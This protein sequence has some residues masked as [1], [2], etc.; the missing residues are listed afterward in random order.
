MAQHLVAEARVGDKDAWHEVAG[1]VG[2]GADGIKYG[3]VGDSGKHHL[4]LGDVALGEEERVGAA[5][6]RALQLGTGAGGHDHGQAQTLGLVE[7]GTG[8]VAVIRA[9]DGVAGVGLHVGRFALAGMGEGIG[10]LVEVG[11]VLVVVAQVQPHLLRVL[12]LR[13]GYVEQGLV[14]G[15][16]QLCRDGGRQND[17]DV[18]R[19]HLGLGQAVAATAVVIAVI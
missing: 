13:R 10:Q 9:D 19:R 7:D 18:H 15:G 6:L 2:E 12:L 5:R 1:L 16:L 11:G 8:V 14:D 3:G 17:V 4:A